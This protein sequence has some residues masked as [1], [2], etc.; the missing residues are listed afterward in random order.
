MGAVPS[1]A[2]LLFHHGLRSY[3]SG[4]TIQTEV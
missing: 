1:A 4:S 2:I 3:E